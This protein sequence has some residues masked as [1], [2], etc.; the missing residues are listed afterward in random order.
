MNFGKNA[1]ATCYRLWHKYFLISHTVLTLPFVWCV[2]IKRTWSLPTRGT[3]TSDWLE[4]WCRWAPWGAGTGWSGESVGQMGAGEASARRG[5]MSWGR[6]TQS[7]PWAEEKGDLE[8]LREVSLSRREV[9][10]AVG[11]YGPASAP[12]A[13]A[14]WPL[15]PHQPHWSV[16]DVDVHRGPISKDGLCPG[17]GFRVLLLAASFG[18]LFWDNFV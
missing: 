5:L 8:G 2:G 4:F 13:P 18:S 15:N 10:L 6:M 14:A 7:S 17:I 3:E 9:S 12:C 1:W 11:S 16:G